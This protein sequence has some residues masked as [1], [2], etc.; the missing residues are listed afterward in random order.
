MNCKQFRT[1]FIIRNKALKQSKVWYAEIYTMLM[2]MIYLNYTVTSQMRYECVRHGVNL[3]FKRP[4][5]FQRVVEIFFDANISAHMGV[6]GRDGEGR[7]MVKYVK[8]LSQ[9]F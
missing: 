2:T 6:G 7:G 5:E 9:W 1:R 3:S 4:Q 8:F